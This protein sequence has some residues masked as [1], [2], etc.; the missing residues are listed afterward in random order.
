MSF[1]RIITLSGSFNDLT[2]TGIDS[3]N[4]QAGST[5]PVPTDP[6]PADPVP[7]DSIPADPAPVSVNTNNNNIIS[8]RIHQFMNLFK[9]FLNFN[10][11]H[12]T[13]DRVRTSRTLTSRSRNCKAI[14]SRTSTRR[15]PSSRSRTCQHEPKQQ[16][17]F[18]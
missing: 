2:F 12:F 10:S 1:S 14:V 8:V 7:A 15:A 17:W 5:D 18:S 13:L 6:V 16:R 3:P 11:K 9:S 4:V